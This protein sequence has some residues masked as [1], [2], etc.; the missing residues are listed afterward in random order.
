M[1][2]L[3]S[4]LEQFVTDRFDNLDCSNRIHLNY[5]LGFDYNLGSNYNFDFDFD[6]DHNHS[7][8][9]LNSI[10]Y[11]SNSYTNLTILLLRID[12][13]LYYLHNHLSFGYIAVASSSPSLDCGCMP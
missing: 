4:R 6:F 10:I 13:N 3:H 9:Y 7:H 12:R 1:V 8:S 2:E 11:L 5:N